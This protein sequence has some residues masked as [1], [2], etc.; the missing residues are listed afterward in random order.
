MIDGQNRP[1]LTERE[2]LSNLKA[3]IADADN[4]PPSEVAKSAVGILTTENRKQWAQLR[5][6]LESNKTNKA[7]LTIVDEALFVVCLDDTSPDGPAELCNNFLCGTYH[8]TGS[9]QTG[10]CTNRWYDKLQIIVCANGTAGIN[11][12]VSHFAASGLFW[13]AYTGRCSILAWTDTPF[14]DMRRTYT[15]TTCS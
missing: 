3:I 13:L 7:C 15:Q 5:Q 1:L 6:T 9:V 4:T 11:F 12:E 10:T 2:I 14:F 8:L